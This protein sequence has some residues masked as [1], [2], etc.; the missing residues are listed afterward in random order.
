MCNR[1]VLHCLFHYGSIHFRR[2]TSRW[3]M[4]RGQGVRESESVGVVRGLGVRESEGVGVGEGIRC[5]GSE[6]KSG[7]IQSPVRCVLALPDTKYVLSA[8]D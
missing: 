3:Y 2:L 4:N 8:V 7:Q 6:V 1:C 5:E